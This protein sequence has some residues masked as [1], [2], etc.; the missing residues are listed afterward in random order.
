MGAVA[1][2][3]TVIIGCIHASNSCCSNNQRNYSNSQKVGAVIALAILLV[4]LIG[5]AG[6]GTFASVE[7]HDTVHNSLDL[8]HTFGSHYAD[9]ATKFGADLKTLNAFVNAHA[10][11]LN[12]TQPI[13]EPTLYTDLNEVLAFILEKSS[14]DE[15]FRTLIDAGTLYGPIIMF[16]VV[17]LLA[18]LTFIGLVKKVKGIFIFVFVVIAL[19]L[20]PTY[21]VASGAF[22]YTSLFITS[23]CNDA[24]LFE[25][26]F[27]HAILDL[28]HQNKNSC[29]AQILDNYMNCPQDSNLGLCN[30][31]GPFKDI[32]ASLRTQIEDSDLSM[33]DKQLGYHA[34]DNVSD[35]FTELR[36][37]EFAYNSLHRVM[38]DICKEV[39]GPSVNLGA[40]F[41]SVVTLYILLAF[42]ALFGA[43]RIVEYE[44]EEEYQ[45]LLE[46]EKF[47]L[48]DDRQYNHA[49]SIQADYDA[50]ITCTCSSFL[51][52]A[53][54][55]VGVL[56]VIAVWIFLFSFG[57]VQRNLHPILPTP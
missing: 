44:Q 8:V 24:E 11:S 2:L 13:E 47:L 25:P 41:I 37:C 40:A 15:Q 39:S 51:F 22:S 16:A 4:G 42:V 35:D 33:G 30:P 36:S 18:L 38:Y 48:M 54:N 57:H 27:I 56:V 6:L 55:F 29:V 43:N 50:T 26:V 23:G 5:S 34:I 3:V 49:T 46:D 7:F 32:M 45:P 14:S 21:G 53:F 10:A 19:L 20:I 17:P 9:A 12:D 1:W 28:V 52:V 31:D